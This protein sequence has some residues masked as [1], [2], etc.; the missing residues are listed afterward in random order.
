VT[1]EYSCRFELVCCVGTTPPTNET[2]LSRK[3]VPTHT[4]VTANARASYADFWRSGAFADI[5]GSTNDPQAFEL[6]RR[7]I[8][9]MSVFTSSNSNSDSA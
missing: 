6:E 7:T 2:D 4:A 3:V 5:A 8:Q 1:V 9:S